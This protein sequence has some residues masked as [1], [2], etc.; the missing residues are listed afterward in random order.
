MIDRKVSGGT[1]YATGSTTRLTLYAICATVRMQGKDPTVICQPI[2]L[3]P[4]DTPSPLAVL[5]STC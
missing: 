2:L 4:P 5:T 3:A 1:C